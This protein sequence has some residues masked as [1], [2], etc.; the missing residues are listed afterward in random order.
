MQR[1][2]MQSSRASQQSSACKQVSSVREHS[3][4]GGGTHSKTGAPSVPDEVWRQ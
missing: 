4:M 3:F 2:L 1:A